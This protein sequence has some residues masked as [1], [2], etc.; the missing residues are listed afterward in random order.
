MGFS[1]SLTLVALGP[2]VLAGF[3]STF[4]YLTV[5]TVVYRSYAL[6]AI[7]S[8][9]TYL[10]SRLCLEDSKRV[11]PKGP[12]TDPGRAGAQMFSMA[13]GAVLGFFIGI[14]VDAGLIAKWIWW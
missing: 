9:C 3:F 13:F 2:L 1:G 6:V 4:G 8:V 12:T 14:L 11:V 5:A 7:P 10:L